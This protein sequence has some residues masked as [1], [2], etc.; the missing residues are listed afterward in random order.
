LK[1][2]GLYQDV[3]GSVHIST[4]YITRALG[5]VECHSVNKMY[6]FCLPWRQMLEYR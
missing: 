4:I 3:I 6:V 2:N 1:R 5:F